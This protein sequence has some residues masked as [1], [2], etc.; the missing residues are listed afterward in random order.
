MKKICP[1]CKLEKSDSD[2]NKNRSRGDGLQRCC[3]VCQKN[4]TRNHYTQNHDKYTTNRNNYRSNTKSV[5]A[6]YK[7]TLKC[8]NCGDD[9]HYVLDFHHN[10]P[11]EKEGNIA[12]LSHRGWSVDRIMVEIEKCSILCSNCHREIHYKNTAA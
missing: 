3:R 1:V 6:E 2:F 4:Y 11:S 10:D 8:E 12:H 5:L 9:R 7:K